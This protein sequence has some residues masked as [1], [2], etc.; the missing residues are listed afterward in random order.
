M[1]ETEKRRVR[2]RTG[3]GGGEEGQRVGVGENVPGKI[4]QSGGK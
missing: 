1:S 2:R 4:F 3:R